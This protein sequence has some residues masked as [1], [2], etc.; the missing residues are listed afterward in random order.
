MK[1]VA[2]LAASFASVV[3]LS[4]ATGIQASLVCA[5]PTTDLTCCTFVDGLG[6]GH[7]CYKYGSDGDICGGVA[8]CCHVANR[9]LAVIENT[10]SHCVE[11]DDIVV[12]VVEVQMAAPVEDTDDA[13]G[14]A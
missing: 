5:D 14:Q 8:R 9:F 13:A 7:G 3:L 12:Q 11:P 6:T 4:F 1:F 10:F 2:S